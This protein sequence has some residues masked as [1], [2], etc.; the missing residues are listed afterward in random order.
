M[1]SA[2]HVRASDC[3]QATW[4]GCRSLAR[5][6]APH[7]GRPAACTT[8]RVDG[9]AGRLSGDGGEFSQD[10]RTSAASGER[11][12]VPAQHPV[13]RSSRITHADVVD[14]RALRL[15]GRGARTRRIPSPRP[16][17]DSVERA[18]ATLPPGPRAHMAQTGEYDQVRQDPE[19]RSPLTGAVA[20]LGGAHHAALPGVV[21]RSCCHHGA[22]EFAAHPVPAAQRRE[23]R[24]FVLTW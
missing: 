21:H 20:L 4:P 24:R 14:G 22:G 2:P 6:P 19:A 9:P 10:I 12:T 18:Y 11:L 5:T 8:Q 15:G 23:L 13:P 16:D 17:P 1:R 7:E 3:R